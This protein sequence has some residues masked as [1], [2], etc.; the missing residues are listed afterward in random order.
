MLGFGSG[1][2]L[3]FRSGVVATRRGP[4]SLEL[5]KPTKARGVPVPLGLFR[6]KRA[7][8]N[9]L[10]GSAATRP[11]PADLNRQKATKV[12]C[13]NFRS[14]LYLKRFFLENRGPSGATKLV[15]KIREVKK[16]RGLT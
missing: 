2:F 3:E 6:Q 12:R 11:K 7:V 8:A 16:R 15:V 9:Y 5:Q 1:P 4:G 10:S 13:T 14:A